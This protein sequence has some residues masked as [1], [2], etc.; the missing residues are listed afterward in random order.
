VVLRWL[1]SRCTPSMAFY[2]VQIILRELHIS[3]G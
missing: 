2:L 3:L 1:L